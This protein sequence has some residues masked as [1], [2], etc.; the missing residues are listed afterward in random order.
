[1]ICAKTDNQR[2]IMTINVHRTGKTTKFSPYES[3]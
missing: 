1:V 2:C 3:T